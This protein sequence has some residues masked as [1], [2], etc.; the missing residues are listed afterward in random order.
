MQKEFEF[1]ARVGLCG[2]NELICHKNNIIY[3]PSN[4]LLINSL[5]NNVKVKC[6][7]TITVFRV[8]LQKE[9]TSNTNLH[10]RKDQV[11][12]GCFLYNFT[13]SSGV[14]CVCVCVCVLVCSVCVCVCVC[15]CVFVCMS[16]CQ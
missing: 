9:I 16:V 2:F 8:N 4:T 14:V 3:K 11:C 15:V 7:Q 13:M 1:D 6:D 10:R 5:Y 12:K